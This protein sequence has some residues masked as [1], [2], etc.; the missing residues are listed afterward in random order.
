MA[1]MPLEEFKTILESQLKPGYLLLFVREEP[2]TS[3]GPR[4]DVCC[5]PMTEGHFFFGIILDDV[6]VSPHCW[7]VCRDRAACLFR[8]AVQDA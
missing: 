6:P 1:D 5:T 8:K 2:P 7:K 3:V 4:C